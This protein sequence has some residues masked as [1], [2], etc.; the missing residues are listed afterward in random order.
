MHK[1]ITAVLAALLIF[2]PLAAQSKTP[3]EVAKYFGNKKP[4]GTGT[5]YW[6]GFKI[7]DAA[8]WS[9]FKGFDVDK[10]FLLRLTYGRTIKGA[11]L[12]DTSIEEIERIRDRDD[13]TLERYRTILTKIFPNVKEGDVIAAVNV[14]E[15]NKI[16]FY[17]NGKKIGEHAEK[18]FAYDFFSIW[19]DPETKAASL[20]GKLLG[21]E[22]E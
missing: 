20:R 4:L 2:S 5:L 19:L 12:V 17:F 14:P 3:S 18:M 21:L 9:D 8:Y 10:K 16:V 6:F 22:K 15:E 13:K 1:I 11:E 7:Y